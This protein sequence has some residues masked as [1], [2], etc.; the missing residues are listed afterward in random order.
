VLQ[1]IRDLIEHGASFDA[2]LD[3][4]RRTTMFTTHTPVPAGH[5]AF[6]FHLVEKHLA[7]AWGTLGSNRE[8][9]LALGAYDNGGGPQFNMTALAIRSAGSTNA[10]SQLHGQV[11]R[12]MFAPMWPDLPEA[13]RPVCGG[14]ERRPRADLDCQ[15]ALRS[16]FEVPGNGW[17]ERHDDPEL[18]EGV[19]RFRITS[20]G[21]Y[22]RRCAAICSRSCAIERGGAGSTSTSASRA[23]SP[24]GRCSIR[25]R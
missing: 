25:T 8:R 4:I 18:W 11:T 24:R 7:G 13:Q 20:C 21:R 22:A 5:D 23:L 6:P 17:L 2:A 1:R 9:F 3:E 14:H 12:A 10:V 16:L 15:R 19:S